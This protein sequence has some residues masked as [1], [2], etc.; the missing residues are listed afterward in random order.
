MANGGV[1]FIRFISAYGF[2]GCIMAIRT[3]VVSGLAIASVGVLV[4]T[5]P[6]VVEPL[7]ER[8]LRV[9][10]DTQVA[11]SASA[12][13]SSSMPTSPACP[14]RCRPPPPKTES[15]ERSHC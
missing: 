7:P 2:W 15:W 6:A 1:T 10:A 4:A 5:A 13:S 3:S 14:I 8:D 9:V 11:L 12:L